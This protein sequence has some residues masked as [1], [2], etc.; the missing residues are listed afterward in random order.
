MQHQPHDLV[1]LPLR[2][3]GG[4][5]SSKIGW[6]AILF[7][8]VTFVVGIESTGQGGIDAPIHPV[9]HLVD[10]HGLTNLGLLGCIQRRLDRKTRSLW[11]VS[12]EHIA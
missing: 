4:I 1:L 7:I 11:P 8:N 3:S 2:G 9:L 10:C 5:P 6:P 12:Y